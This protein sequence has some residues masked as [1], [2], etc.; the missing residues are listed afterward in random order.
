MIHRP[1]RARAIVLLALGAV[2]LATG[3]LIGCT[4]RP[5]PTPTPAAVF[6]TEQDAFAAA[7]DAYGAYNEAFNA[8]DLSDPSTFEPVFALTTSDFRNADKETLS[9]LSAAGLQFVGETK[10]IGFEGMSS[11]THFE[12]VV[13]LVC[14]DLSESDV[15]NA[16]GDSVVPIERP[17]VNTLRVTFAANA[18]S[19]LIA[20]ADREPE[21][22]CDSE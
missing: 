16:A 4:L 13:A 9:E 1:A 8:I 11:T 14:I 6:A 12:E 7:E 2:A 18:G 20:H 21:A 22:S 10:I 5:A 15:V 17:A 19:V 3:A